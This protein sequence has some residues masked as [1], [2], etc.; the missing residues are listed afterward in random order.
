MDEHGAIEKDAFIWR[1]GQAEVSLLREGDSWRIVYISTGR[2]LGP[3]Y[4][5]YEQ[6]HKHAKQAAWDLMAR[7]IRIS[8]DEDQGLSVAREAAKWMRSIS[9][10]DEMDD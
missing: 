7:V 5:L 1:Q 3:K 4:V 10:A 2:L 6:R 8:S 9:T